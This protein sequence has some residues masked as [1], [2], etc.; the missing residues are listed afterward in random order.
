MIAIFVAFIALL[1]MLA[2][3]QIKKDDIA[4]IKQEA[5][6]A[7]ALRTTESYAHGWM[8]G[9]RDEKALQKEALDRVLK[10]EVVGW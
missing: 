8:D 7:L 2:M 5:R 10:A 3:H 1:I 9:M 6:N 4:F